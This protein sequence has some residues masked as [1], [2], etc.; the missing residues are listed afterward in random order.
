MSI[1]GFWKLKL[2]IV[3]PI[4]GWKRAYADNQYYWMIRLPHDG[5]NGLSKDSAADTFQVK[6]V[7]LMRFGKKLGNL[8]QSQLDLIAATIAYNI[9][10]TPRHRRGQKL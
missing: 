2:S 6:S 1:S 7:S 9:C 10:Y 5:K 4:T 3:V 8:S